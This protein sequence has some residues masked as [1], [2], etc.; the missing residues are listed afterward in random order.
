M[1]TRHFGIGK[2]A[3]GTSRSAPCLGPTA[4][5]GK[6]DVARTRLIRTPPLGKRTIKELTDKGMAPD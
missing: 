1:T 3:Y 4:I 5:E 2:S 6:A